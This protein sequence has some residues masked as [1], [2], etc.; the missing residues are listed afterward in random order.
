MQLLDDP[1]QVQDVNW[2]LL[3]FYPL[4]FVIASGGF[5]AVRMIREGE[6]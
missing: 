4:T 1:K 3:H 5:T 6:F 2:V